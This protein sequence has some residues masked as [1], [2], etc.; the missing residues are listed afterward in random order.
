MQ[1]SFSS[2]PLPLSS[3]YDVSSRVDAR[4]HH[5]YNGRAHIGVSLGPERRRSLHP[6][7]VVH[8]PRPPPAAAARLA[9]RQDAA[10]GHRLVL[11]HIQEQVAAPLQGED[12]S[13]LRKD[14]GLPGCTV[15]KQAF[16]HVAIKF[17][18]FQIFVKGVARVSC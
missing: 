13:Q 5:H 9:W 18:V 4:A 7:T 6:P 8:Q 2:T 10:R 17:H 14:S 15:K 3:H 12:E 16:F 11:P 1:T